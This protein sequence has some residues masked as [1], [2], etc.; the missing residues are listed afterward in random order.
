MRDV[1]QRIGIIRQ[2]ILQ[3]NTV[4]AMV[5][6]GT[7]N[8][9]GIV[10]H[11]WGDEWNWN[12]YMFTKDHATFVSAWN[13]F[14]SR[15]LAADSTVFAATYGYITEDDDPHSWGADDFAADTMALGELL[16]KAVD[17]ES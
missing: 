9:W 16:L 1:L 8:A 3:K 14:V 7:I 6:E 11:N 4:D 13:E 2:N 15:I 12:W 10:T 17:M 5:D